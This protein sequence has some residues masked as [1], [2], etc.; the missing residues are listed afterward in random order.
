MSLVKAVVDAAAAVGGDM[1]CCCRMYV[2]YKLPQ[3][4]FLDSSAFKDSDRVEAQQKGPYLG[5]VRV[6][7]DTAVVICAYSVI[8]C[9]TVITY[10]SFTVIT[11]RLPAGKLLVFNLFRR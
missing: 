9:I 4:K 3:L 7:D 6:A 5:I 8:C 11:G 1:H 2:L 10:H